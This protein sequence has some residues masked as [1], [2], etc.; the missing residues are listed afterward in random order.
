MFK[1]FL[2][3]LGGLLGGP[4]AAAAVDAY[5]ARLAA[6]NDKDKVASDLAAREIALQTRELE[7]QTQLRIAALGRWYE[8]DK[9]M[10]YVVAIYF[11][12]LLVWDKVL[13]LGTT[14]PLAGWAATTANLIVVAYFSKRGIENIVRIIK[15]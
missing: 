13:A 14:D 2:S 12:K 1:A 7:L 6:G 10:G 15:R 9:I 11:A 4:F 5:K 3:W 8:P